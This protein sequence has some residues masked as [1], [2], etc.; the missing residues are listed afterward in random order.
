MGLCQIVMSKAVVRIDG[1][2]S[3][4]GQNYSR[5][6]TPEIEADYKRILAGKDPDVELRQGDVVVVK[7]S[8]F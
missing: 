4:V 3:A 2:G 1:Q 7:E 5:A 8:F 6:G